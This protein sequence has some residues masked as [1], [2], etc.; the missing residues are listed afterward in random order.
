MSYI[1]KPAAILFL[2]AGIIVAALSFVYNRT[3][4][5]IEKQKFKAQEKAM[6]ELLPRASEYREL[7]IEKTDSITALYEAMYSIDVLDDSVPVGYIIKLSPEGYSGTIDFILGISSADEEITG[8]RI[9]RHSETPGLGALA[10]NKE[11]FGQFSQ[12][13]L[14]LLSVVKTSP[15]INEIQAITSATITSRAI[16]NAVNE[17][18]EWYYNYQSQNAYEREQYDHTVQ[19][20]R[21]DIV[22]FFDDD[23]N[24]FY[25]E[26]GQ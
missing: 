21:Y 23:S 20:D 14:A 19:Y 24:L 16:T 11:F 2:T 26:V 17:A 12:R 4:E 3:F 6:G 8:I 25:E 18:I 1:I 15:G 5:P 10:V 22:D 13:A 7:Q 9:L